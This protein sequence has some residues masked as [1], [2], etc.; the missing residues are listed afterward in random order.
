MLWY[1]VSSDLFR[2]PKNAA[3]DAGIAR[4]TVCL[5]IVL[6]FANTNIFII[7]MCL[8]IFILAKSIMDRREV[9]VLFEGTV[10]SESSMLSEAFINLTQMC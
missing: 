8:D 5:T 2:V 9:V 1:V 7:K 6:L 4:Y 10:L 3:C